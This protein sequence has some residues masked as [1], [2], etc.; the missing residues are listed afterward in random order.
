MGYAVNRR[1]ALPKR[2]VPSTDRSLLHRLTN[3][4]RIRSSVFSNPTHPEVLFK[5]TRRTV[6]QDDCLADVELALTR[7]EKE[8][9]LPYE[10]PWLYSHDK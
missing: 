3:F 6:A 2:V 1:L 10:D 5:P 8:E 7:Q 9:Q 4:E